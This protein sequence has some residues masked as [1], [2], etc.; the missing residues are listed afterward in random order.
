MSAEII[1]FVPRP[2]SD[3]PSLM[4]GAELKAMEFLTKAPALVAGEWAWTPDGG[5]V[6]KF[7]TDLS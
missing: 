4:E 6:M 2:R 7:S 1:Q 3:R 5:I